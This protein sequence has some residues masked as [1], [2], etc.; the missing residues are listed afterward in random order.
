VFHLVNFRLAERIDGTTRHDRV[1][2][3]KAG[4]MINTLEI[5]NLAA[6]ERY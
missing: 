2:D 5:E 3:I 4:G 6:C 1:D